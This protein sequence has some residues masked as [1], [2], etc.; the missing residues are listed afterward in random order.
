[1]AVGVWTPGWRGCA[2]GGARARLY[3]LPC[4]IS[5]SA[6]AMTL[7]GIELSANGS[8]RPSPDIGP[9][10]W[11]IKTLRAP[12]FPEKGLIRH[13]DN[14]EP[15]SGEIVTVMRSRAKRVALGTARLK[16]A[17]GSET[18]MQLSK[19][20]ATVSLL[21]LT[22]SPAMAANFMQ[23]AMPPFNPPGYLGDPVGFSG[24]IILNL[25]NGKLTGCPAAYN[26]NGAPVGTCS[27]IG[28]MDITGVNQSPEN[29]QVSISSG[30]WV[31]IT[32][33]I[34]GFTAICTVITVPIPPVPS[35]ITDASFGGRCIGAGAF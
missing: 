30:S 12:D 23:V 25:Q 8:I 2:G 18:E 17:E 33:A 19:T 5:S 24:I 29:I 22:A 11:E 20:L 32:N 7:S 14:R 28:V 13:A 15:R 26:A 31:N 27:E 16:H 3:K 35:P 9:G 10:E 1:M 21:G 6:P 4:S 34:T